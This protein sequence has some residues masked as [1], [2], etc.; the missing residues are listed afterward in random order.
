MNVYTDNKIIF[1]MILALASALAP[2]SVDLLAPSLPQFGEAIHA[3]PQQIANS[4]YSF[5]IG[6]GIAPVLWGHLSDIKGR[7]PVLLTGM[8]LY[9]LSSAYC[10]MAHSADTLI[11]VRFIQGIGAAA[12]ATVARAI[13]RD[14]YRADGTTKAI[15]TLL[16]IMAIMPVSAPIIGGL[17]AQHFSWKASFIVMTSVGIT[18]VISFYF[19]I[20]E[21]RPDDGTLHT[22]KSIAIGK[23][24]GNRIFLQHAFCNMFCVATMVLFVTNISHLM[25]SNYG[26]NT[27]QR[28]YVLTLFNASIAAGTYCV[29]L[30]VP[31]FGTDRSIIIG[32]SASVIGWTFI[33]ALASQ[34]LPVLM[35]LAPAL[36]FSGL[37]C[38]VVIS[39]SAGRSLTPFSGNSGAA[40]SLYII[41]QSLGA[42]AISY[43]VDMLIPKELFTIALTMML[44]ALSAVVSKL[45]F[46][47]SQ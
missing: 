34:Q 9:S 46:S 45:V 17:L 21:T 8:L 24:L 30:L 38:G 12:G 47:A 32:G 39:L 42:S 44:C 15:S 16:S 31:R 43:G 14:R 2:L 22:Q 10:M 3:T 40:S 7:R 1:F 13:I 20:A 25:L 23:I 36:I 29:W 18:I 37:G 27:E 28:G 19:F 5:L 6:Y 26:L 33:A 35:S 11:F 4:I 41:I